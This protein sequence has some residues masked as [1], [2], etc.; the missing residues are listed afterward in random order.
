[1]KK[2]VLSLEQAL[3]LPYTTQRFVQLGWRVI[4]IESPPRHEN[5]RGG[6]PNRYIGEDTGVDDLHAYYIAPN[7]GKE[8]ITLNLKKKEGQE[9]LKTLIK[10]LHV[11]IFLCNTL[12]KR[13][14][15]LGIDFEMLKQAN[16][17]LIWC[18]IS[19]FGPD[20]PDSAGYDPALQA[21][22]GY[23]HLTGDPDGDPM[24]CGLPIID[25]KAGDE[26]FSQVLLALLEQESSEEKDKG[27]ASGKEIF[28]SMAQCA[29]SWLITALPQIQFVQDESELFV[30]SGS[31]HRSFIP[32]NC[33]PTRDGHVYLAIGNDLQWDKLTKIKGF[34]HLHKPERVSNQGRNNEK[35]TIY[36]DIRL[37]L[38]NYTTAE[39]ID[40]CTVQSLA[41]APVNST[42]DV[43]KLD[44]ARDNMMKTELPSGKTVPLFPAPVI[45]DYLKEVDFTLT[46][47]PR[48]GEHND[49][50][51]KEIG[52]SDSQI[53]ELKMNK[54]I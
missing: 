22:S 12:P 53:N 30:R 51:Y 24:L 4:R 18:G 23:M 6:D 40:I 42:A 49:L 41:V 21:H 54:I 31:E 29:S 14:N 16:P 1:M 43:A 32:C 11:D 7:I 45:T 17:E 26:A 25:L 47:S 28:I 20:Y 37:G 36:Q 39:F 27:K 9:L 3:A 44:F 33:Y 19:A 34:E 5:G 15:E 38:Q 52:F 46:T 8:A 2:T 35:E 48:L 13:Y 50:I 10:E